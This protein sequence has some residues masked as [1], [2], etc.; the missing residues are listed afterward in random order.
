MTDLLL[1]LL[2]L[3]TFLKKCQDYQVGRD[4]NIVTKAG[5]TEWTR[6]RARMRLGLGAGHS[7]V[8]IEGAIQY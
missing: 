8:I 6:D 1:R 4:S 5:S 3:K 7:L 2:L